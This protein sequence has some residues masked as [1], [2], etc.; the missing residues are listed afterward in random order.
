MG[1]PERAERAAARL[2]SAA[3]MPSSVSASGRSSKM[4]PRISARAPCVRSLLSR[5]EP[6]LSERR[7]TLHDGYLCR[8][9]TGAAVCELARAR[10]VMRGRRLV[11]GAARKEEIGVHQPLALYLDRAAGA[12]V[13]AVSQTIEGPRGNLDCPGW[14][15]RLHAAGGVD[16]VAPEVVA[17]LR[18]PDHASDYWAGVDA[19]SHLQ[20]MSGLGCQVCD[21]RPHCQSHLGDRLGVV[22][23]P[24]WD[25]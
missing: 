15:V 9:S 18:A 8:V 2:S 21:L 1:S 3:T 23:P 17:E 13:V 11:V 19:D 10:E 6:E 22:W 25:A 16:G 12:K 7:L 14:S 20:R 5:A 24:R 4:R